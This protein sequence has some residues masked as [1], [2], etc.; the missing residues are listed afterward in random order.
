MTQQCCCNVREAEINRNMRC[1]E[2]FVCGL[3]IACVQTINRN[4]RCI[5]IMR[6]SYREGMEKSINRNMRCIEMTDFK[7]VSE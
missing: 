3:K 2:I 6:A 7:T 5:E 4:M 1:I